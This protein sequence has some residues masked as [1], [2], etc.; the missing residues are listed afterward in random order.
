MRFENGKFRFL[1]Q[2][3][4]GRLTNANTVVQNTPA[5]ATQASLSCSQ[6]AFASPIVSKSMPMRWCFLSLRALPAAAERKR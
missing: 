5:R 2:G 6:Q 1:H 4:P 3:R